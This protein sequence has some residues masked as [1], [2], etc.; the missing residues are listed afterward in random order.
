[1][2]RNLRAMR[3]TL[4]V[5]SIPALERNRLVLV[6]LR[7]VEPTGIWVESQDF[8]ERMMA[9]LGL[10]ASTTMLVLFVPFPSIEFIVTST[11]SVSLSETGLGLRSE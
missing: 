7:E 6:R 4:V 8:T 9:T 10:V 3:G 5:A 2:L 11:E 1:M